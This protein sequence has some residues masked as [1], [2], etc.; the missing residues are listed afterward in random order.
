M[1]QT[2]YDTS[3][4]ERLRLLGYGEKPKMH[5]DEENLGHSPSKTELMA[6]RSPRKGHEVSRNHIEY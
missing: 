1:K 4:T 3:L 2:K 5:T 6:H